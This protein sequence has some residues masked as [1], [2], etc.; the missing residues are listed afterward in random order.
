MYKNYIVFRMAV[1]RQ[2]LILTNNNMDYKQGVIILSGNVWHCP[3]LLR[4]AFGLSAEWA[5]LVG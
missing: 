4:R 5:T 2:S 3:S 1:G